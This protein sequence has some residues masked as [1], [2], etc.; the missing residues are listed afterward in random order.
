MILRESIAVRLKIHSQIILAGVLAFILP[1][2]AQEKTGESFD[3]LSIQYRTALYNDPLLN[4]A[5][6]AL[7]ALYAKADRLGELIGTYQSHIEQYPSDPGAKTVLIRAMQSAERPGVDEL[8][9]SS[10][11]SHPDYAPLQY[12]LFSTLDAKGDERSLDALSLAIDLEPSPERRAEWLELLLERSG[13]EGSREVAELQLQKILQIENTSYEDVLS[14]ARLMQRYEF[15][16]AS[17]EALKRASDEGVDGEASVEIAVRLARALTELNQGTEAG[18]TLDALLEKLGSNHWRRRE[19][20]SMRFN[21]VSTDDER[22]QLIERFQ[23]EYEANPAREGVILDFA[24]VLIAAERQNEAA[25]LL[26]KHAEELPESQTIEERALEL[27]RSAQDLRAYESF[28]QHRL[29]FNPERRKLRLELVKV[30]YSLGQDADAGQDFQAVVAGLSPEESSQE[31]L[32]LQRYLRSIDREDAATPYLAQFL[33]VSPERLDVARELIEI[34]LSG[35]RRADAEKLVI[36]LDAAE[37]APE[38]VVD[39]VEYLLSVEMFAGARFILVERLGQTPDDFILGV[40]LIRALGELGD[41]AAAVRQIAF[42]RDKTDSPERYSQWLKASKAAHARMESIDTFLDTEQQRF[43]FSD[44]EWPEAKVEKFLILCE[45]SKARLANDSI[46]AALR[47]RLSTNSLEPALKTRLQRFLLGLLE[48]TPGASVEVENLLIDLAKANPGASP[49]YDL[50]RA[51]LY[52]RSQQLEKA[53]AL[54]Q[55]VSVEQLSSANTLREGV[56]ALLEYR[57]LEQAAQFLSRINVLEP[58]DVFSWSRRLSLLATKGEEAEFRQVTRGLVRGESGVRLHPDSISQLNNQ[59]VNSY[60]RSLARLFSSNRYEDVLPLLASL[61]REVQPLERQAWIEW[62]RFVVLA[63]LARAAEAEAA[64]ERFVTLV[65]EGQLDSIRFPDGLELEVSAAVNFQEGP[66]DSLKTQVTPNTDFLTNGPELKWGFEAPE[67]MRI[68]TFWEGSGRVLVVDDVNTVFGIDSNDGRLLWQKEAT[69][70]RGNRRGRPDSFGDSPMRQGE[71]ISVASGDRAR[72][73]Q[74]FAAR[75]AHFFLVEE[76]S[77][78]CFSSKDGSPVWSAELP[79]ASGREEPSVGKADILAVSEELIVV[80]QPHT[81]SAAGY[82]IGGGKLRWLHEGES[83]AQVNVAQVDTLNS[84]AQIA[85]GRV[86]LYGQKAEILEAESGKRIWKLEPDDLALLPVELKR[87][88]GKE[89]AISVEG[90]KALVEPPS[91]EVE[92]FDVLSSTSLLSSSLFFESRNKG[93]IV[94]PAAYW[95]HRRSESS[96]PAFAH[97]GSSSIWLGHGAIIRRIPTDIPVGSDQLAGSGTFLGE[98]GSHGWFIEDGYLY[99]TDF[100]RNRTYAFGVTDLG[101]AASIRALYAGNQIVVKGER[102]FKVINALSGKVVGESNW[103]EDVV[104]YLS[105]AGIGVPEQKADG[106]LTWKGRVI[107]SGP[108]ASLVCRPL[109]DV[110]RSDSYVTSFQER[111]LI[112]LGP[113]GEA[114]EQNS[115]SEGNTEIE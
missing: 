103:G 104:S 50:R 29:E 25:A 47:E 92:V 87:Y 112:C 33:K 63:K 95:A 2:T 43:S 91:S 67:G 113:A 107:T 85:N 64:R 7:V 41:Q 58:E 13:V 31:I 34:Y 3:Q 49:E 5:L 19:I 40:I 8:L 76:R 10:V 48:Y 89:E 98:N 54:I 12:L 70:A 23:R 68:R 18:Q 94:S 105:A 101:D 59:V 90:S 110:I 115:F 27:L 61:E 45:A 46:A 51:L 109:T 4:S 78:K 17:I 35:D 32:D 84:G 81:Q 75:G 55:E 21:M 102:G 65:E 26:V 111:V 97:L 57:F 106:F 66:K 38:N 60:W 96:E 11:S 100:T 79:F 22:G 44:D 37:A 93:A 14:L 88:R 80:F 24:D 72:A 86:L 74:G 82:D 6:E 39:L 56:E 69:S 15:W 99:H 1:L 114:A 16:G 62:T 71:N 77:L 73:V 108:R 30:R 83:S 28:L 20:M 52:H 36:S 9:A 42:L 53:Q